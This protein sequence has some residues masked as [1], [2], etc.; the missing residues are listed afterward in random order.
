MLIVNDLQFVALMT[1]HINISLEETE[2][3]MTQSDRPVSLQS[4]GLTKQTVFKTRPYY[5]DMTGMLTAAVMVVPSEK[6]AQTRVPA[7]CN[8]PPPVYG[9]YARVITA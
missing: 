3:Q 6:C 1:V 8:P 9:L 2:P 7:P 5:T 4:A